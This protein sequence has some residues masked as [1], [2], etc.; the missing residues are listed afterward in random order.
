[1]QEREESVAYILICMSLQGDDFT[2][3]GCLLATWL[4]TKVV[5][6]ET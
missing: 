4:L 3:K 1:M 6:Y 5:Y 2:S